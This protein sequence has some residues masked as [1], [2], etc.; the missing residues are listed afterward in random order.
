MNDEIHTH[1]HTHT[2]TNVTA[3]KRKNIS[4]YEN[5]DGYGGI[6]LSEVS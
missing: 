5:I 2:H 4:N 1:T 3:I 6:M